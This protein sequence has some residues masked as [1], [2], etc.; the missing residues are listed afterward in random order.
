[1]PERTGGLLAAGEAMGLVVQSAVGAVR[2]GEPMTFGIGG[3]ESNVAIGARRL[4]VASTWVG[5]LGDD[6]VGALIRRELRAEQVEVVAPT[7]PAPTGLMV[8]WRPAAG[9]GQVHYYRRDSAGSHLRPGDIPDDLV[10]RAAV[11]HSTGITLA[12]GPGPAAAIARARAAARAA[13]TLVSF[14]VNYRRGLWSAEE[15]APALTAA[16]READVVFAG[17]EEAQL[18]AEASDPVEAARALEALGPAQVIIKLG[19]AGCVARIDGHTRQVPAPEVTV[20]DTVGAGDAFVA[21][22]LAELIGGRDPAA[23]LATAVAAGACAVTVPGD[24][25]GMPD[26]A[27]L[28]RLGAGEPV[29]R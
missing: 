20:V 11:F 10:G 26:R 28:G 29:I 13:G 6:P 8:R 25:E 16:V 12:L 7:D 5:R 4:G 15:A 1:M 27:A 18:I 23:R 17:I 22:Y 9:Q 21:G 3:S 19:G 2:N 24:W 14:D